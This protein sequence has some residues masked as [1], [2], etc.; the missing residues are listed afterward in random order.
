[1]SHEVKVEYRGRARE[2]RQMTLDEAHARAQIGR[3]AE[4]ILVKGHLYRVNRKTGDLK[5]VST[6]I[7][8]QE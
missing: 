5:L 3:S 8:I 6:K 4:F 2:M 1:M 7:D